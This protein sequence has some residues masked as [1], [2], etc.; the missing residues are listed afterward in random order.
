[1]KKLMIAL[2]AIVLGV[3]SAN[4]GD[5]LW[6]W[7]TTSNEGKPQKTQMKGCS[8]GIASQLKEVSGAQIDVLFNKNEKFN[9]GCQYAIG[10][11]QTLEMRNGVQVATVNK[12]KSAS[13]QIGLVCIN[14]TGFLPFFIFFNFDPH[15]FGGAK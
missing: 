1:M 14:D 13:L 2:S 11:S 10:Y 3:A 4:A 5:F 8:L 12:A 7:W 9:A 15:M 6:N